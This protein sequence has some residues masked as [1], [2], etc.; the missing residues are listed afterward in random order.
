MMININADFVIKSLIGRVGGNKR[1][2]IASE[3]ILSCLI[4]QT[5]S[6]LFKQSLYLLFNQSLIFLLIISLSAECY[7][8]VLHEA[9]N[10]RA[11]L[12]AYYFR[13]RKNNFYKKNILT[14][15]L[16]KRPHIKLPLLHPFPAL[17]LARQTCLS[18][19]YH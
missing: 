10:Q 2:S 1:T 13:K 12:R 8:K 6:R 11:E 18:Q 19:K 7:D 9:I 17:G 5:K 16:K 4:N 14:L 15:K 3:S